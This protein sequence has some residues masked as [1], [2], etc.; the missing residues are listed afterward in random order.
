MHTKTMSAVLVKKAKGVYTVRAT[1]SAVDRQGER[2]IPSG[3]R[4]L[5]QFIKTG[6]ILYGHNWSGQPIGKPLAGRVSDRELLIDIAFA[7]T[8][9]GS[10]MEYLYSEGFLSNFSIGFLP[11]YK[12]IYVDDAG[13]RTYPVWD[14]LELSG[15]PVPA[16]ADATMLRAAGQRR[17]APL[18]AIAK[19]LEGDPDAEGLEDLD[20]DDEDELDD[21]DEDEGEL[22]NEIEAEDQQLEALSS[23]I[24]A[25]SRSAGR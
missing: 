15:T 22:E 10:E 23:E 20:E 9:L 11:E 14:L 21:Q 2:V 24:E 18:T 25:L 5:D 13:V 6:S 12:S 4:N 19:M 7:K 1:S 3:V 17:G 8:E 16:N